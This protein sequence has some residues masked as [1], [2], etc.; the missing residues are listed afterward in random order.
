M[1]RVGGLSVDGI[2]LICTGGGAMIEDISK[3]IRA[4]DI[5]HHVIHFREEAGT[6]LSPSQ[7]R[8][9]PLPEVFSAD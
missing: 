7:N 6:L 4:S 9:M 5:E 1:R 3:D 2:P 8:R